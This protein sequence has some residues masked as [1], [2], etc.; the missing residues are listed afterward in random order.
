M[1]IAVVVSTFP[2]I[3]ETFVVNQIVYLLDKGHDV[4]IL[5]FRK[6]SLDKVHQNILDYKLLEKCVYYEFPSD[7]KLERYC[8]FF[9]FFFSLKQKN[10]IVFN[11]V[12]RASKS[13]KTFLSLNIL[14]KAQWFLA[15]KFDLIHI[16]W[17][18]NAKEISFLKE[19]KIIKTPYFVTF[20]G[21]DIQ[22]NLIE[23]Y[24]NDYQ[25]ILKNVSSIFVNTL[26]TAKLVN[27]LNFNKEI[28]IL[29][30]GLDTNKF[31]RKSNLEKKDIF[32]IIFCGRLI[33]LKGPDLA[34]KILNELINVRGIFKIEFLIIGEG[35]LK[36]DLIDLIEKFN[37]K[38]HI[39]LL[40]K[41]N[42]EEIIEK[43]S[44]SDV[45]LLPGI[46][47]QHTNLAETQGLVIQEAQSMQL[48]VIVSDV[49]GMKY[50][51]LD[52]ET[53]FVV[54]QN[55]IIGFSDKIEILY[56]NPNLKIKMGNNARDFV[57][58]NY[59]NNVLGTKLER[60]FNFFLEST[61]SICKK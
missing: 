55:D 27:Q 11:N 61:K 59:D 51:V 47:E 14:F 10:W 31:K 43:M 32:T 33:K 49:G 34:I 54:G 17:A 3:S 36:Q 8:Q 26:Y 13:L 60:Q 6:G 57:T 58:R 46:Q 39:K 53:G 24:R 45:F 15:Y 41:L 25:L 52:N 56:N 48:P 44:I 12:V 9:K 29:P 19:K 5:A 23:K 4:S 18:V 50:G 21:Y 42:Q 38:N 40:G 22:P 35:V 2:S 30:M 16:H 37:L 28:V 1:K 20:H 7:S